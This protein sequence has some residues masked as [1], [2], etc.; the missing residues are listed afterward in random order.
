MASA[1]LNTAI[2]ATP[3]KV[4]NA[5]EDDGGKVTEF[6][7]GVRSD[8]VHAAIVNIPGLHLSGDGY[9]VPIGSVVRFRIEQDGIAT[10]YITGD[11]EGGSRWMPA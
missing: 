8:S 7:V 1:I 5:A 6:S 10:V 11:G 2:G 9:G 4:F 3:V